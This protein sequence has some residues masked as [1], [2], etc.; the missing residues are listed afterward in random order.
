ML[1]ARR[2]CTVRSHYCSPQVR[3]GGTP[4]DL[5]DWRILLLLLLCLPLLVLAALGDGSE[6]K[7]TA[8]S[9]EATTA[10]V[11]S[12]SEPSPVHCVACFAAGH[13]GQR[14][15][16]GGR[17]VRVFRAVHELRQRGD[18]RATSSSAAH[19]SRRYGRSCHQVA[20]TSSSQA[21]WNADAAASLDTHRREAGTSCAAGCT[22]RDR[23]GPISGSVLPGA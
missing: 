20:A 1:R 23:T 3:V 22:G 14:G 9:G 4:I 10:T 5:R 19:G 8:E 13:V 15:L 7:V 17:R 21:A 18:P 2:S 12:Q 6:R 16:R 11:R